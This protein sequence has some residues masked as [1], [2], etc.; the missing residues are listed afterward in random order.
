M[1]KA[2]IKWQRV[3]ALAKTSYGQSEARMLREGSCEH[4]VFT[5][6]AMT[7]GWMDGWIGVSYKLFLI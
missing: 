3:A 5:L 4:G 6:P 1:T 2:E 7:A